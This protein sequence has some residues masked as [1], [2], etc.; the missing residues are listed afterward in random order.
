MSKNIDDLLYETLQ[1]NDEPSPMLNRQIL[2]NAY[3]EENRMK[4]RKVKKLAAAAI[5]LGIALAG[6]GTA[7]AAYR[8]LH[9]SQIAEQVSDNN[10][11]AKAFEGEDAIEINETQSSNGYDITLLGMVTGKGLELCIPTEKKQEIKPE[12][13][14][15]A[16]AIGK[17]DGSTMEDK[18]FCIAPLIDGVPFAEG[19]AATLDVFS[20]WFVRD[21]ILYQLMRC[22]NLQIFADRGVWVSVVDSFGDEVAAF[23]MDAESGAYSKVEAYEGTAALFAL[24]FDVTKADPIAAGAYLDNI[25]NKENDNV[26]EEAA[27]KNEAGDISGDNEKNLDILSEKLDAFIKTITPDNIDQYFTRDEN[28]VFTA[29][30]DSSNW[31][32]FGSRYVKEEDKTYNGGAGYLDY[33]IQDGE[34]FA[35]TSVSTAKVGDN[36]ESELYIGVI[37]RN[38]DGS[39]TEAVYIS[40]TS[41]EELIK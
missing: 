20:T 30:P 23:Q 10:A 14:Y 8:Y 1:E 36:T 28:S 9:P 18:S 16:F 37:F 13:S 39:F 38:S 33:W 24:P 41:L 5:V 34:D 40:K 11:L 6:T 19:N 27:D 25:R 32:E 15:A 35:I 2:N 31:I 4:T 3:L 22:D 7:Y 29:T 21:G 12:Y 26:N 17:S